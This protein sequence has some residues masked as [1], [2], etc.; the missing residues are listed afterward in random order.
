MVENTLA[1]IAKVLL[2]ALASVLC[3]L[4]PLF[5]FYLQ[6]LEASEY[7]LTII[8]G[9]DREDIVVD[10]YCLW[11]VVYLCSVTMY[12]NRSTYNLV[13]NSCPSSL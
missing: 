13:G 12:P 2:E 10:V 4:E 1:D 9:K 6:T 8:D 3:E 7:E 5:V 11:N